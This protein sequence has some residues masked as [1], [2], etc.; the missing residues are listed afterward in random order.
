MDVN[1]VID[2]GTGLIKD[3]LVATLDHQ[4]THLL[5]YPFFTNITGDATEGSYAQNS[6]QYEA[7]K[8]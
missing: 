3:H 8:S 5:G 6:Q 2:N 7:N 1:R 4:K